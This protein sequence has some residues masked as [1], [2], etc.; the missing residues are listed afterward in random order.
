MKFTFATAVLKM[1]TLRMRR[2]FARVLLSAIKLQ[3]P[4]IALKKDNENNLLH[5]KFVCIFIYIITQVILAF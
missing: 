5:C 2:R 3:Q 4:G 1:E